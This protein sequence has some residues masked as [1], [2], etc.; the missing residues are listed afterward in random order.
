MSSRGHG[1]DLTLRIQTARKH[2]TNEEDCGILTRRH[3]HDRS[4]AKRLAPTSPPPPPA[5]HPQFAPWACRIHPRDQILGKT[6]I[7]RPTL[8]DSC[9]P[10]TQAHMHIRKANI[11]NVTADLE[12]DGETSLKKEDK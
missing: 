2:S 3:A 4:P 9:N 6:M 8:G 5:P 12:T 7:Y 11:R 10:D 1:L